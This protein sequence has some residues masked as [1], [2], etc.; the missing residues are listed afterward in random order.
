MHR[1]CVVCVLVADFD[2]EEIMEEFT[3]GKKGMT[4]DIDKIREITGYEPGKAFIYGFNEEERVCRE[5]V[6]T[7][8]VDTPGE[9]VVYDTKTKNFHI[10]P[11]DLKIAD[12]ISESEKN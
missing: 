2:V 5:C 4:N 10:F 9:P 7:Y 3:M 11:S 12:T 6:E 8:G 1:S